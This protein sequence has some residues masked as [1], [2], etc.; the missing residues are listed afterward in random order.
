MLP[1]GGSVLDNSQLVEVISRHISGVADGEPRTSNDH[2]KFFF[3]STGWQSIR[4]GLWPSQSGQRPNSL[5]SS[6]ATPTI[7]IRM[8]S[9][10]LSRVLGNCLLPRTY[11]KIRGFLGNGA[12]SKG[13]VS[14]HCFVYPM[15]A[16]STAFIIMTFLTLLCRRKIPRFDPRAEEKGQGNARVLSAPQE[17]DGYGFR[18]HRH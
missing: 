15:F 5:C 6:K 12:R 14:I 8:Q 7:R 9:S 1:S 3:P 16:I 17:H 18:C 10:S 11:R 4:T 2:P 13:T